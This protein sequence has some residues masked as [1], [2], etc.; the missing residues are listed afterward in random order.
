LHLALKFVFKCELIR[1][2]CQQIRNAGGITL[3]TKSGPQTEA[4]KTA[5]RKLPLCSQ[6]APTTADKP[7]GNAALPRA[8]ELVRFG[9]IPKLLIVSIT[10]PLKFEARSKI[11]YLGVQS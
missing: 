2:D 6:F 7:F 10:S 11:K 5:S 4:A 3:R 8:S 1:H 9:W